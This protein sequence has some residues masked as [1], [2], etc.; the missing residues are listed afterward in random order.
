MN[1]ENIVYKYK[2]MYNSKKVNTKRDQLGF[3]I[4]FFLTTQR[5]LFDLSIKL[6]YMYILLDSLLKKVSLD[7]VLID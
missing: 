3:F 4:C 6:S 2:Y 5:C 1:V 7:Y